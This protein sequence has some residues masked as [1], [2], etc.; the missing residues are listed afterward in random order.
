MSVP[1]RHLPVVQN[2]DCQG[3]S[4]CCREYHISVTAEERGRIQEQ[5]WEQDPEIGQVPLFVGSGPPWARRYRLN[6]RGDGACVF[7]SSEGRCRIH[8]RFGAAAKPFP[9]RLYP[10]LLIPA[11]DHWR[12]GLRYAC[13]AAAGNQGRPLREFHQ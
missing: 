9:C 8:E 1:V 4:N 10:F 3:C 2:W 11:G 13:P 5:G 7:L 6:Q 12:V